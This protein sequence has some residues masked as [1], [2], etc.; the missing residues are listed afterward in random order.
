[1]MCAMRMRHELSYDAPVEDVHAMLT[2]P[3]FREKVCGA[4]HTLRH[5]VT[6]TP[7]GGSVS[8][9][10]D[11]TQRARH[12]PSFAKKIVGEEIRIVQ[13]EDWTRSDRADLVVDIPGK[14]GRL[15]GDIAL[16]AAGGRTTE[17]VAGDIRVSLPLVGAKLEG[18]IGELL[19]AALRAE[20]RVGHAWLAG[21]R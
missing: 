14:P 7:N 18:L 8:V 16:R 10:V 12:I 6:V 4:L 17:V 19:E 11:Q 1:M 2:D 20:E 21:E 5:T 13:T 3:E 15:D 9:V